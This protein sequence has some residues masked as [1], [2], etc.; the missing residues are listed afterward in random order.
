VLP[1]RPPSGQL[2]TILEVDESGP[3]VPPQL[4]APNS[5][6]VANPGDVKEVRFQRDLSS[7]PTKRVYNR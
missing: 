5:G 3:E 4:R 1:Q 6:D 7:F 2:E